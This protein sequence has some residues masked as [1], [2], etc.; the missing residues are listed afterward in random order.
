[1]YQSAPPA[2]PIELIT[3]EVGDKARLLT[4][5]Q[6][7]STPFCA[8]YHDRCQVEESPSLSLI[9]ENLSSN[10]IIINTYLTQRV[11]FYQHAEYE[12]NFFLSFCQ[13]KITTS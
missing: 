11:A 7:S 12:I 5:S 4:Y 9:I 8:H 13:T 6:M 2:K 10:E 3:K 1:M